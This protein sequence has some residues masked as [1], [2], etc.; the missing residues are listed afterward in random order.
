MEWTGG[1][2]MLRVNYR[3][4]WRILSLAAVL[5]LLFAVNSIAAIQGITPTA[6]VID[7]TAEA[8]HISTADGSS[9]LIW[10]YADSAAGTPAQYPGPTIILAQGT[11]VT[12]T[13]TNNLAVPASIVFPGQQGV[14]ASGGSQGLITREAA[15]GGTVSY[16]FTPQNPGTYMYHSGTRPEI[17]V[18]MGL[19][20]AVIVRPSDFDPAQGENVPGRTAYGLSSNTGYRYEYLY[21]LSEMDPYIHDLVE[22]GRMDEVDNSSYAPVYWFINGRNGPDTLA[23]PNVPWLR[24]QPYNATTQAH[25]GDTILMRMI[26]ASRH[27]HPFHTHGNNF[28]L[29]ARDGRLL[30]SNGTT[31]DLSV[32]DFTQSVVPGETY[33]ALFSWTGLE[34]GWDYYGHTFD[35]PVC[36]VA[37]TSCM[38]DSDCPVDEFCMN[39]PQPAEMVA[40]TLTAGIGTGNVA[41]SVADAAGWP[42]T[43]SFRA[44]LWN[45]SLATPNDDPNFEVVKVTPAFG[46]GSFTLSSRGDEGTTPMAWSATDNIALTD[47]GKAIPV[48][49]PEAQDLTFGGFWSGSPYLGAMGALPPG[50]G[51]LNVN[52]GFFFMWHSHTEKELTNFDIFPGGMMTMLIVEPPGVIIPE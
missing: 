2:M 43:H 52:G 49:L 34:L 18:E 29:I 40:T 47:H 36:S 33:D 30:S 14:V 5:P 1:N 12:V 44:V 23:Q 21:V 16:T 11:P 8:D 25:P 35:A 45:R 41:V 17:Q 48:F 39:T 26:G 20:G 7:L 46:G 13:L 3:I 4:A 27:E 19:F 37:G 50:E 51:G 32:S 10:G 22:F 6:G 28:D 24:H 9:V 38:Q 15:S 31:P 42:T